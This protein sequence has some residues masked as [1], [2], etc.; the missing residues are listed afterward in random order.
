MANGDELLFVHH[1]TGKIETTFGILEY[2][3]GDYIV[4]PI[5]TIYQVEPDQGESKFL[6]VETTSWITTPKRY[7]NEFG[8]FWSTVLFVREI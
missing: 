7:R 3:R 4:I 2:N 5:G 1:G 6:V 8:Q